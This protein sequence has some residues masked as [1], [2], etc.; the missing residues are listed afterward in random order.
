MRDALVCRSSP[1]CRASRCTCQVLFKCEAPLPSF[2]EYHVSC[3][4]QGFRLDL[5]CTGR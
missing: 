4:V 5:S 2:A 1:H 3:K